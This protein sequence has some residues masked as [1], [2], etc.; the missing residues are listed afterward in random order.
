MLQ[1]GGRALWKNALS[2]CSESAAQ[3]MKREKAID[4]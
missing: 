1:F 4:R 3:K 2:V